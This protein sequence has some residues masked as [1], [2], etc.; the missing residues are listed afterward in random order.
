MS[1]LDITSAP[2]PLPAYLLQV[3]GQ[4][5]VAG[6]QVAVDCDEDPKTSISIY[7]LTCFFPVSVSDHLD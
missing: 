7:H 3:D 1:P 6:D 2:S 5:N 4:H